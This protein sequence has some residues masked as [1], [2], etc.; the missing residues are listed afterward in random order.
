M[1][2]G[3]DIPKDSISDRAQTAS[4]KHEARKSQ[5]VGAR[6]IRRVSCTQLVP[7]VN[8]FTSLLCNEPQHNGM[9]SK[10]WTRVRIGSR[11]CAKFVERANLKLRP[12]GIQYP[13]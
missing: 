4:I 2:N 1:A 13:K 12:K 9:T 6:N 5:F 10:V 11:A 3:R 8:S 7:V